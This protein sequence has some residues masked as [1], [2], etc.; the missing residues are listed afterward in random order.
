MQ[1][2]ALQE[3]L[4]SPWLNLLPSSFNTPLHYTEAQLQELQGTN[5]YAATK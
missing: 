3:S 1:T 4:L 5:L 2:D